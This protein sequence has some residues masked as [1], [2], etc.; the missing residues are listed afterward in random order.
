MKVAVETPTEISLETELIASFKI[1]G[2]WEAVD[3]IDL[4]QSMDLLY[5]Y[6]L[7]I[8]IQ[9]TLGGRV[10][11]YKGSHKFAT[12]IMAH[13][14][15]DYVLDRTKDIY[16]NSRVLFPI[17]VDKKENGAYLVVDMIQYA[18]PGVVDLLGIGKSLKIIKDLIVHYIPNGR[19]KEELE[20][21]QQKR[22][23]LEIKNLKSIGL[24]DV[25]IQTLLLK[26]GKAFL[27]LGKLFNDGKIRDLKIKEP[28]K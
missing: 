12:I 16:D 4:L 1:D 8:T 24:D 23:A 18:S 22:I 26:R 11:S 9:I 27:K 7:S 21:L 25:M 5:S 15:F 20:I 28:R 10:K 19:S 6:Y 13:G 17:M 14:G 3:L 2:D